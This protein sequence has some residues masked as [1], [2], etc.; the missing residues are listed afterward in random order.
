[1][2]KLDLQG[3]WPPRY[4]G[5]IAGLVV[6]GDRELLMVG[7]GDLGKG[8][9]WWARVGGQWMEMIDGFEHRFVHHK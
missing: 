5:E 3:A 7:G 4:A 6:V 2:L 9:H 8:N 1:M